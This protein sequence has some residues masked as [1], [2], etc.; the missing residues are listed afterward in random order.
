MSDLKR[1]LI[2]RLLNLKLLSAALELTSTPRTTVTPSASTTVMT[3]DSFKLIRK[4]DVPAA[5]PSTETITSPAMVVD[6]DDVKEEKVVGSG[7]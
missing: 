6:G 1:L 5:T 4:E 2:D 7:R 3:E